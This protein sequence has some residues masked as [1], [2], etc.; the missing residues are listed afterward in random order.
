MV[1]P[2]ELSANFQVTAEPDTPDDNY[3]ISANVQ[4]DPPEDAVQ[5]TL[6]VVS[7]LPT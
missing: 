6:H 2:G 7:V 4:G 1:D 5:A 3:E